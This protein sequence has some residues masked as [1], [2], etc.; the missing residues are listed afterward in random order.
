[1][2]NY[3]KKIVF[4][5]L[6][7]VV[8]SCSVEENTFDSIIEEETVTLHIMGSNEV[9]KTSSL[10]EALLIIETEFTEQE[11][12]KGAQAKI[13]LLQ[14]ELNYSKT[15]NL[16]DAGVE[17]EY[18]TYVKEKYGPKNDAYQKA[19]TGIL[20][21]SSSL[22]GFLAITTTPVNLRPSKRDKASAWQ[23]ISPGTVIL[24]DK[25]W[26]RGNKAILVGVPPFYIQLGSG[27]YK[28]DN[29]T[30]SFF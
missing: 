1:M 12:A 29:K 26:F 5:L 8:A 14:D 17:E 19:T 6:L 18:S 28:F 13:R 21:D 4:L 23:A 30:D 7:I 10:E 2:K 22:T 24:C 3:I 20:W 11:W 9:Y 27:L 16:E 25:T 15:L